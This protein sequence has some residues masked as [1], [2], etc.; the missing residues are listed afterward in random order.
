MRLIADALEARTRA[1]PARGAA[2]PSRE[3]IEFLVAL[4]FVVTLGYGLGRAAARAS[5]G[6]RATKDADGDFRTRV[7]ELFELYLARRAPRT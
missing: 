6:K 7:I 1:R 5:L 4:S 3:D 2:P